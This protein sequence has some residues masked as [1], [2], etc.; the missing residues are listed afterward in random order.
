MTYRLI[1]SAALGLITGEIS[2]RN[3]RKS[4]LLD[5]GGPKVAHH[6]MKFLLNKNCNLNR[7]KHF[8]SFL[9]GKKEID[10]ITHFKI[11]ITNVT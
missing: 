1:D 6:E 2:N 9:L 11:K 5:T 7:R 4:I 10:I 3:F 8:S